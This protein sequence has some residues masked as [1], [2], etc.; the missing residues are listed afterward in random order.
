MEIELEMLRGVKD[1][2]AL[3]VCLQR[4]VLDPVVDHLHI[5]S[6]SR[7]PHVRVS[8]LRRECPEYRLTKLEG[9]R[10]RANHQAV[11]VGESPDSAARSR[12]HEFDS[13][14]LQHPRP[15]HGFAVIRVSPVDDHI[16]LRQAGNESGDRVVHRLSRWNHYPDHPWRS[17]LGG[18]VLGARGADRTLGDVFLDCFDA[19][20][21]DDDLVPTLHQPLRHVAAHSAEADHRQPH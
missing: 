2:V 4:P 10:R 1:L 6:R 18:N 7:R 9:S 12:I 11:S 14:R 17:E 13:L 3:R 15:A 5:M 16:A 19:A 8:L 20:I 21:E